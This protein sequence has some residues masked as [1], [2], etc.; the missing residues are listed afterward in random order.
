MAWKISYYLCSFNNIPEKTLRL[1]SAPSVEFFK[2]AIFLWFVQSNNKWKVWTAMQC[3]HVLKQYF[4]TACRKR[5]QR[6]S[7]R[8]VNHKHNFIITRCG[9]MVH[10]VIVN[11]RIQSSCQ[12]CYLLQ[13]IRSILGILLFPH[14]T[15]SASEAQR[16]HSIICGIPA[17]WAKQKYI[18]QSFQ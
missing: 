17:S 15:L 11:P 7:E 1:W 16:W 8:L 9:G 3:F 18:G 14:P 12:D 2:L 4:K 6:C 5:F 13:L 10:G